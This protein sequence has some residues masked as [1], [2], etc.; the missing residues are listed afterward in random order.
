MQGLIC[1]SITPF[2]S[3]HLPDESAPSLLPLPFPM[4]REEEAAAL[5]EEL[6]GTRTKLAAAASAL[7]AAR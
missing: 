5:S 1:V 4:Q 7:E 6:E 2:T 3:C